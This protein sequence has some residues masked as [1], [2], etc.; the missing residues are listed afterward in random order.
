M[1]GNP[2]QQSFRIRIK[3]NVGSNFVFLGQNM[4]INGYLQD[5]IA[6]GAYLGLIKI[7]F[8]ALSNI[9]SGL[10]WDAVLNIDLRAALLA[11]GFENAV[12]FG[13]HWIDLDGKATLETTVT[14]TSDPITAED[15]VALILGT[16]LI[17]TALAAFLLGV[18]GWGLA[19]M[20]VVGAII[21]LAV[22]VE[23]VGNIIT[24]PLGA[25]VTL[26][27]LGVV[28]LGIYYYFK[29]K[30]KKRSMGTRRRR[31]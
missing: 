23:Q 3:T 1:T 7:A 20:V 15:I 12:F 31:S 10:T 4:N 24:N 11:K 21:I 19:L 25:I 16:T 27:F 13:S 6:N 5:A 26:A 22:L 14:G 18:T 2:V 9:I 8:P 29:G 17:I 28:G 30:P